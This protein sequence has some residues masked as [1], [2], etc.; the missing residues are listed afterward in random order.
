MVTAAGQVAVGA[1]K[2]GGLKGIRPWCV[3]AWRVPARGASAT[4]ASRTQAP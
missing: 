2:V 4:I 3:S 1:Q